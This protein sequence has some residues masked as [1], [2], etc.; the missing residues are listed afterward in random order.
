MRRAFLTIWLAVVFLHFSQPLAQAQRLPQAAPE[1]AGL[2]SERL[3]RIGK[4]FGEDVEKGKLPGAVVAVARK[5][6]LVYFEAIGF[7]DKP[8]GKGMAK[9][10][11]FRVYSMT[12]PWTS[13]AAMMLVEDGR[14]QLTDPVSKYLPAF[15][16]LKVSVAARDP[17]TGQETYT[18]EPAKREP[19]IQDLLR[20][21]S[22]IAYDFVTRNAPVKEAYKTAGLTALGSE[23]REKMTPAEFV[24]QLSKAPLASQPGSIWEYSLSSALLGRVVEAVSGMPLSKFLG[25]RLFKP[26]KMEDS[27]FSVSKEKAGRVAQPLL[28][29]E[30]I[31][32]FDPAVPATNELGGEGGLSTAADYLRFCQM[33]LNGGQLDGVRILSPTTVALM[34]SDHLGA[35]FPSTPVSPGQLLL[36][37]PGYTFGLGFMVRQGPGIAGVPGSTGEYMWGG[38]AGTFFWVDPKEELVAV[39][40]S[41]GPFSTRT[42]YRRLIKQLVYAAIVDETPKAT[43]AAALAG[44]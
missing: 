43:Q 25:E 38:A 5:G 15:K 1:S 29:Y 44:R 10:S 17:A 2:S 33:L 3:A 4:I 34:T 24:D 23:I 14:I 26:L 30:V 6:K 11:I 32:I 12:K 41:Q 42:S 16:D 37:T 9:D 21:T 40:M 8:A 36:G 18:L 22:G 27:S 19:T 39:F 7:Q 13:V 35:G 28:P 31:T 20:H